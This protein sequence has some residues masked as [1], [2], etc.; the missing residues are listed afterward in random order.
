MTKNNLIWTI[1]YVFLGVPVL[2]AQGTTGTISGTVMDETGGVIPGITVT[3]THLETSSSRNVV[4][5]DSGRYAV[6]NLQ[7]GAYEVKGELTGFQTSIRAGIELTVGRSAVVDLTMRVGEITELVTVTGEASLVQTSE[8]TLSGLVTT[9]QIE[10]LPL[11]GRNF[12]QLTLLEASVSN[13]MKASAARR[14]L[15]AGFGMDITVAGGR[16][17]ANTFLLDGT[18]LNDHRNKLPG[19]VAGIQLGVD[20]VRE[21]KMMTSNYS[22]EYGRAGGGVIIAVTKSGTNEFH[23][24]LF[25]VHRNDVLDATNFF[26]NSTGTGKDPL[27]RNQFGASVGGPIVQDRTFFFASWESLRDRR[28]ITDILNVPTTEAKLGNIPGVLPFTV[29]PEIQPY[30]FLYPDVNG[31]DFGDGRGEH[32]FGFSEPT[33]EDYF[34]TKIDHNLTDKHSILG[35]YTIDYAENLG[36][37][38]T[39]VMSETSSQSHYITLEAK[40]VLT[41]SLLNVVS[42]ALARTTQTNANFEL[43][44]ID[45]SLYFIPSSEQLGSIRISGLSQANPYDD[46]PRFY[47]QNMF[48]FN[49]TV[50]YNTGNHSLKFGA[51]IKRYHYNARSVS[52]WGGRWSFDGLE[53]YLKA[54][55]E[56]VESQIPG[57]DFRRGMRQTIFGFYVQ[58]NFQFRPNLT[59][60]LGLRYEPMQGINEVNQKMS[61]LNPETALGLT[62][63]SECN[64]FIKNPSKQNFSP[65]IG[66]AWDPFSDEKTSIRAAYGVFHDIV[67]LYWFQQSA[68]RMPPAGTVRI[69]DPIWPDPFAAGGVPPPVTP[70][71]PSGRITA[72]SFPDHGMHNP[73][74]QK[75]NLNIQREIVPGTVGTIGYVGTRGVK[76]ARFEQFQICAPEFS[77]GRQFWREGCSLRSPAEFPRIEVRTAG[78]SS[79]YHAFIAKLTRRFSEG[80]F[81]Q[82]SYTFSKAIDDMSGNS[83]G[84]E[85]GGVTSFGGTYDDPDLM[86]GLAGFD[87]RNNLI[88]NG[89]WALPTAPGMG[90]VARAILNGW[91][92]NGILTLSD[93]FPVMVTSDRRNNFSRA[94][95]G[96]YGPNLVPGGDNNP[97]LGGPDLYFDPDQFT[98]PPIIDDPS[99]LAGCTLTA[100]CSLLGDV[101]RNT[102]TAPGVATFDFSVMKKWP[103]PFLGEEGNF[104]FRA[105]FFNVFNR[106][107]FN[108][109]DRTLFRSRGRVNGSA[110]RISSTTTTERQVQLGLKIIF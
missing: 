108:T 102:L 69:N 74:A 44:P 72:Y 31:R 71:N 29:V 8:T 19:S 4:S 53:E 18:D 82:G 6:S 26:A 56:V 100:R 94:A 11:N 42:Y 107:N 41:P 110:G 89:S 95:S 55:S 33:D 40:S 65:R 87:V 104:E 88:V 86:R 98:L 36:R 79:F 34:V 106:T 37:S 80:L 85:L 17:N 59:I 57:A 90:G 81:L 92:V 12:V 96:A 2:L 77:N 10:D 54:V 16:P 99:V 38:N 97:V 7:V 25:E 105:E 32:A 68:F 15:I 22:A 35:R 14:T 67:A 62:F 9:T 39:V 23:G 28:G 30:L 76:L 27:V 66:I 63:E 5:N 75:W 61:N 73:Y 48:Q 49:D 45:P 78:A 109:P 21:F 52:R 3:V 101:G 50:S 70:E 1:F 51:D 43:R 60:N 91:Q 83:N 103:M 84:G 13:T 24:S 46:H 64:C 58:D 47:T 20:S 93:G